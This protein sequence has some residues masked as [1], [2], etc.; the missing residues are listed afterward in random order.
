MTDA[1]QGTIERPKIDG[2][3]DT[4]GALFPTQPNGI[5]FLRENNAW[6]FVTIAQ[7]PEFV[8]MYVSGSENAVQYFA[9][10]KD[11][12]EAEDAEL[13]RPI[14]DY[15]KFEPGKKVI[16]FQPRSLFELEDPIPYRNRTPYSL[17]YIK[18]GDFRKASGTDDL[19]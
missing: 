17:R 1:V 15:Q 9:R 8:A 7:E 19:F 2:P 13:A 12:V 4:Q 18:L 16:R 3:G 11:I 6:G 10:V 5:E 14:E